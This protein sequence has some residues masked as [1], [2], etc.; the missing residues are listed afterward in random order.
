MIFIVCGV[1]LDAAAGSLLTNAAVPA[2]AD[3]LPAV[4]PG[5]VAASASTAG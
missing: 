2:T 4:P 3:K 1:A 5:A